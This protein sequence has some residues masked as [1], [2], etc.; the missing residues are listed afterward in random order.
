LIQQARRPFVMINAT[1]IAMG[2]QFT[3][4]QDQ[5]DLLCS[6]LSGVRVARAVAASSN[7][8]IAFT[9]LV[10]KNYSGTC[11]Y[12]ESAWIKE[13]SKDL[14][15][16]PPRF[17][18]ARIAQSY[19][20]PQERQYI[21]L[22]D[23]GI[24][25]NIGLRGPL[26]ALRSNDLPW[27]L[28]SKINLEKVKKLVVVVVDA[29]TAPK[30]EI[31]KRASGPGLTTILDII[32]SVPMANYSFD[33]VQQVLDTF[34][35][36]QND[37]LAYEACKGI[38]QNQCPKAQMPTKPPGAIET[39]G[40]YVGFDQIKDAKEREYFL[41][42]PTTFALSKQEVDRLRDVGPKILHGSE[43]FKGLL[44]GLNAVEGH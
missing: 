13:A 25:D 27:N 32:S 30:T 26:V 6:D 16:N 39:Y 33:S 15:A 38:L 5:F 28:P 19:L 24:A 2:S 21:H 44:K 1:D 4:I 8:P 40:V 12:Q 41:N 10:L 3:F 9:P 7:F 29:R 31:D 35:Q 14:L 11:H 23:G 43:A 20:N 18:R 34:D 36:W 42:L 17:N 37:R 22:L